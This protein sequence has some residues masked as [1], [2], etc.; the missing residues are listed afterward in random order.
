MPSQILDWTGRPAIYGG[1]GALYERSAADE[2]LRPRV[3]EKLD[4]YASLLS[5]QRWR[6]LVSEAR[7]IATRGLVAAA[8]WQKADYVSA[9]HWRP[10]FLGEDSEWGEAAEE[11]LEEVLPIICVRGERFSWRKLWHLSVPTRG[12]DGGFFILLTSAPDSDFPQLQFIEAHRIGQREWGSG[13]ALGPGATVDRGPYEGLRILNG[14]IYNS[15]GREVAYRVLGATPEQDE[16]VSARDLIHVGAARWYSE[17]RPLP[18]V[19]PAVLDLYAID[20][21]RSGQLDQQIIDSKITVVESNETGAPPASRRLAGDDVKS[22]GGN[23]LNVIERAHWRYFKFGKGQL[24][25]WQTQRPSDQ[26]MNYDMRIVQ[27]GLA[28]IGWRAEMLDPSALRGA[29]TRGF[30]DQINTAIYNSFFDVEP[31]AVR[32]IRYIVSKLIKTGR[33][34]DN[35]EF[36]KWG[37]TP[38]PEF[39]V[40]RGALKTDMDA[41]RGGADAMPFLHRRL[42]YRPRQ[43]LV[44]QAKYE[45]MKSA[46]AKQYGVDPAKLGTLAQPGDISGAAS[47]NSPDALP[48]ESG[49]D[50]SSSSS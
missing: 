41:V 15:A 8:L 17:G 39:V 33:L 29:A 34:T 11:A 21:A 30:Q 19:A 2:R 13:S 40:D 50:A 36:L 10:Q 46:I 44:A 49:A 1:N 37:I 20:L 9:S 47:A 38:P 24:Q 28:A 45:S 22:E 5:P 18:E 26:W 7:T 12:A 6:E 35:P 27:T 25:P 14:V 3:R 31:Q 43:V 32:C 16:D 42:G 23:D 4:D 48:V